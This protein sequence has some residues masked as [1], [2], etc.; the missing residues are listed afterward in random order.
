MKSQYALS[1][2]TIL[3][4]SFLGACDKT[5]NERQEEAAEERVD[6]REE[7][8]DKAEEAKIN[9]NTAEERP[10]T[11]EP[12]TNAATAKKGLQAATVKQIADARC[13]REQKCGNLGTDKDYA[14]AEVCQAKITEKWSDELNAYECPGGVVQKELGECLEEIKNEDCDSPFDTLGRIVA[15]RSS[16]ICKAID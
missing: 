2:L 6:Q 7:L 13:A 5:A 16:D 9:A 3:S 8:R 10:S 1:A 14:S 4:L 11:N 15:C 12:S